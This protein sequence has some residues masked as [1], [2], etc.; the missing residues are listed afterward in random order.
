MK[1][2]TVAQQK[3]G[4]GKTGIVV[5]LALHAVQKHGLKVAVIDLDTQANASYSLDA[6]ATGLT[7]SRM[8][9]ELPS[10]PWSE[11]SLE[12]IEGG[13]LS[14]INADGDLADMEKKDLDMAAQ[15]LKASVGM[16]AKQGYDLCLIDTPPSLGNSLAA[17]LF[18]AQYVL[19]PIEPA[20]Y[21]FQ[22]IQKM[23]ATITN[24]R[25]HNKELQFLGMLPSKYDARNPVHRKNMSALMESYSELVLPVPVHLR[26]SVEEAL[27]SQ[28]AV[29]NIKKT[30]ARVATKEIRAMADYVF[31]KMEIVQ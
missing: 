6:H 11:T 21:S 8:F 13:H 19:S 3:G 28:Q 31:K 2:L 18:S 23:Y 7:S 27:D 9:D 12:G 15:R 5:H 16:L 22:G 29:W 26:S 30:A 14:L 20:K 10:S 25:R 1:A 4:V 24:I 17:A